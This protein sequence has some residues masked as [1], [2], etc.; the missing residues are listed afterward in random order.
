[1]TKSTILSFWD[2]LLGKKDNQDVYV[3]VLVAYQIQGINP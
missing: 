1:M 3:I 2:L